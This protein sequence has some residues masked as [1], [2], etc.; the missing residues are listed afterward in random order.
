V[1]P[2]N[3]FDCGSI[4]RSS[5]TAGHHS[6]NLIVVEMSSIAVAQSVVEMAQ[7]FVIVQFAAPE[8][9]VVVVLKLVVVVAL[10]AVELFVVVELSVGL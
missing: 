4:H 9:V 3:L 5:S 6:K 7:L 1:E 2:C 10:D 8:L